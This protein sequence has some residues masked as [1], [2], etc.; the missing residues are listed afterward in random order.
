MNIFK[1]VTLVTTVLVIM[2]ASAMVFA[3]ITHTLLVLDMPNEVM[4]PDNFRTTDDLLPPS[5]TLT[6]D[7]LENIHAAGSKQFSAKSLD[8]ALARIPSQSIVVIDLR[9]ESHG[10][11]NGIGVSWFGPQNAANEKKSPNEI[12]L[13]EA[14]LLARLKKS[15]FKWVYQIIEKTS[16][17]FIEKT[18]KEFMRVNNVQSEQQ[19]VQ[20]H[21]LG[22]QRFYVEDF[23]APQMP[24]VVRFVNFARHVPATTW[25]YFHCRAGKGRTTTFMAMYDMM[26]NAKKV[27]FA[28]IISRQAALG[29]TDLSVLPDNDNFKYKFAEDRYNFL[30]KFYEYAKENNDNYATSYL[31]WLRKY[32]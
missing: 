5:H 10:L 7:G 23:H 26:K 9:R 17:D 11:L 18:Q 25:L 2:M 22:Y 1:R 27:S 30:K 29:G 4:L 3:K 24:D 15:H 12:K 31:Q 21:H 16:D 14:R 13:S 6:R 20:A 8:Q 32:A 28:D 19:L